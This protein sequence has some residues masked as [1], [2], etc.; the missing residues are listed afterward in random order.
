MIRIA[1]ILCGVIFL[2]SSDTKRS[3]SVSD[4][5][6]KPNLSRGKTAYGRYP[7][8]VPL[9]QNQEPS[10]NIGSYMSLSKDNNNGP[11][12]KGTRQSS[13]V[14]TKLRV[15]TSSNIIRTTLLKQL[16]VE[17][18]HQLYKNN[19]ASPLVLLIWYGA[20]SLEMHIL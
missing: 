4:R 11:N 2:G 6:P 12:M 17:D 20:I 10:G 15:K 18:R 16:A 3:R 19:T 1:W 8:T 7:P 5:Q 13:K 14:E 9:S